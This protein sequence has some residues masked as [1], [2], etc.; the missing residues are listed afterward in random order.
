M[1]VTLITGASS[2]IG[3]S[4]ARRL[5]RH[6]DAMALV[7]RR[8]DLLE[9]LASEIENAGGRAMALTCDVTDLAQ[10]HSAVQKAETGLG[11]VTRL[12]ANA[13]GG[14]A[15]FVEQFDAEKI[16]EILQLNLI[17]VANC[18]QAVLPDM[19]ER[20]NG[21]LVAVGSLAGYR[22]L[23]T[24]AAYSAAKVGV[25]NLMESLRIDLRP[26]GIAVTL[27][28]PGF[29][30]TNPNKRP[31]R[32]QLDLETATGRMANAIIA[33]KP[34]LAFPRALA[35]VFAVIR[36]L[37]SPLYDRLLQGRGRKPPVQS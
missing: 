24:A 6:G 9:S 29:V 17:G 15:T 36:L 31:K 19:L 3:R 32:F 20:G 30:R 13:G 8:T 1:S 25:A 14:E 4:L 11:P 35:L 5:A 16:N 27:L 10:V 2:G 33:Q 37:P 23:P 7:A 34:R 18:I 26:K 21:H 12:V 28:L 22:G